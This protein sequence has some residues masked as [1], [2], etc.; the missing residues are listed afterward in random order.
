MKMHK[1]QNDKGENQRNSPDK[2]KKYEI[3]RDS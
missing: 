1:N 3:L 2:M